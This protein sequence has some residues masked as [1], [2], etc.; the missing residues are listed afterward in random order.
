M[1]NL[2]LVVFLA[3]G[4]GN[5]LRA[6][7]ADDT[8]SG[9]DTGTTDNDAGFDTDTDS[10]TETAGPVD[11]DA[12]SDTDTGIEDAGLD[13]DTDIETDTGIEDAGLDTDVD[14][15][16]DTGT[17]DEDAGLDTDTQ[18]ETSAELCPWECKDGDV[19]DANIFTVCD[20]NTATPSIVHNY[21][22]ECA[23]TN[24]WCCQPLSAVEDGS[25]HESCTAQGEGF[26]CQP[27]YNCA[28]L[29]NNNFFCGDSLSVCC[30][31]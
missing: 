24:Y 15:D 28:G 26:S 11:V 1:K 23:Q 19:S 31:V 4:C 3:I 22:F 14:S 27:I 21:N 16:T 13:T 12:D 10:E 30:E 7:Q 2:I 29:P 20:S 9:T 17:T 25:I 6:F 5:E 8:D 18:T